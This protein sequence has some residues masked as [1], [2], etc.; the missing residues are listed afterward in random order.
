MNK[1]DA[2]DQVFRIATLTEPTE[3]IRA[4]LGG[5]SF[6]RALELLLMMRQSPVPVKNPVGFLR[7]AIPEGWMPDQLPQKIDRRTENATERYY[8]RKG[9]S[10]EQARQATIESRQRGF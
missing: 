1:H 2:I 4:L 3:E 6:E 7:R 10:P 9:L 5:V 8:Q